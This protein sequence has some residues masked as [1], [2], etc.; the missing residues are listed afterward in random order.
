[1]TVPP[2]AD[3]AADQA[4]LKEIEAVRKRLEAG[5]PFDKVAKEVSKDPGSKDQGGSL[6]EIEKGIMDPAFEQAAFALAAGELSQPVKSRFGYHL[7]QV[8]SV[9]PRLGQALRLGA[10]A[11]PRRDR[12]A[13]RRVRL[14]RHGRASG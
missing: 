1:M 5:E 8:E 6:G 14:L 12:Q 9:V 3:A 2:G 4:A 13:A 10:R 11:A 7:I